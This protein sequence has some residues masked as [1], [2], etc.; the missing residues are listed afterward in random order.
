MQWGLERAAA[1]YLPAYLE[2]SSAGYPLYFKLGFR[3]VD[4]VVIKAEAWDGDHDRHYVAMLKDVGDGSSS[5]VNGK[6]EAL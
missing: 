5:R 2:A 1:L 4:V 3:K 6:L